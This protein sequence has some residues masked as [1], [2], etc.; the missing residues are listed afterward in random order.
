MMPGFLRAEATYRTRSL[1]LAVVAL[2]VLAAVALAARALL[3]KHVRLAYTNNVPSKVPLAPIRPHERMCRANVVLPEGSRTVQLLLLTYGRPGPPLT[4]TLETPSQTVRSKLAGGFVDGSLQR[5]PVSGLDG[6]ARARLCIVDEGS[7]PLAFGGVPWTT[8]EGSVMTAAGK[9]VPGDLAV[10]VYGGRQS[11]LGEA[12][13]IMRRATIW[14]P[15]WVGAWTYYLL[16]ALG[17]AL[18]AIAV[19]FVIV[20][21]ARGDP[22]QARPR[23]PPARRAGLPVAVWAIAAIAFVN[24]AA[25][26]LLVLPWQGPDEISHFAYVQHIAAAGNIHP[27]SGPIGRTYSTEH[28]YAMESSQ[29]NTVRSNPAAKPPWEQEARRQWK[30][31]DEQLHSSAADGGAATG[32]SPEYYGLATVGYFAFDSGDVFNRQF[33]VRLIS[34][35]LGAVTA[36]LVWLFAREL[37][38]REGWL[39]NTAALSVVLLP[40]FGFISGVVNNDSLAIALGS[41]EL[42]L[43]ARGLRRG[44]TPKL[45]AVIGVVLALAYLAKPSLSAFGPIVAGVLAW[46]LVRDRDRRRLLLP[47]AGLAGF[48]VVALLWTGVAAIADRGVSTVSTANTRAFSLSDFG[49]YLYHFYLPSLPGKT[50]RWF[51]PQSPVY[52]V[53]MHGF[54]AVFGSTDTFFPERVYKVLTGICILAAVLLAVAFWRE[55]VAVRRALPTIVMAAGATVVLILFV[56]LT[57]YL[58]YAGYPG[59]QGRYLLPLAPVFGSAVA[60]STLGLGRRWAPVLGAFYVTALGSFTLFSY[61]LVLTRYFS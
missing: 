30:Q 12:P 56:H 3:S 14:A 59:E 61:G 42:Y 5:I 44:L 4:M 47:L 52:T 53:W 16:F 46:P 8:T 54:F 35:L 28:Q 23:P 27:R 22:E 25:W 43:L 32:Y 1:Q 17:L 24:G 31:R 41:L 21:V 51:G 15:P 37:F 36:I 7:T 39:P 45:A 57:F 26:S 50:D 48:A 29:T 10:Q 18:V 34:A 40:Q 19:A 9:K 20:P 33:G 2:V 13:E 38:R 58:F 60:A 49:S 6:G 11:L 55:R